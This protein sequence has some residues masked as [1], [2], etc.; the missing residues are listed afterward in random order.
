MTSRHFPRPNRA[1]LALAVLLA[2][3]TSGCGIGT[4]GPVQAGAPASGM[5]RPGDGAG[6]VR[7]YF[8]GPYGTRRTDAPL[9]P[10]Q[11]L[12]LLLDGPPRPSAGAA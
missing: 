9:A 1:A 8:A 7:L 6:T 4:T 5:Q 10:Q 3:G 11:A 2:A 12:D